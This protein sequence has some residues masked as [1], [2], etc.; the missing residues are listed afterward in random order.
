MPPRTDGGA[1][2]PLPHGGGGPP[3]DR[4]LRRTPG[5]DRPW[6]VWPGSPQPLGSRHH[7]GPGG[8]AGTNFALRAGGAEGVCPPA[9]RIR[10]GA[11]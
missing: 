6:Q 7:L 1:A 2:P 5:R 3:A 11:R 4:S 10:P 9:G 8:V